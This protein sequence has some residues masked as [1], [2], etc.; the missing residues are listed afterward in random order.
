MVFESKAAVLNAV[1]ETA[2]EQIDA[3]ARVF[4]N[5]VNDTYGSIEIGDDTYDAFDIIDNM[6]DVD[7]L[8]DDYREYLWDEEVECEL[9]DYGYEFNGEVYD[10]MDEAVV[11]IY[12][13]A[14]GG[15][16]AD[17]LDSEGEI[18][19]T[20]NG[21]TTAWLSRSEVLFKVDEAAYWEMFAQF[22]EDM[23]SHINEVEV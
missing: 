3:R 20:Y 9:V 2:R 12:D 14:K 11:A 18:G 13:Y 5:W 6:G 15:A 7:D 4:V 8:Y 23:K 21:E 19:I 22:C 16:F 17:L 1:E 10:T